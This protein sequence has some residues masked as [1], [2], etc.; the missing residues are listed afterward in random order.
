VAKS[1]SFLYA[2]VIRLES[3]GMVFLG[4]A[5]RERRRNA[6]SNIQKKKVVIVGLTFAV[7]I[8]LFIGL[9]QIENSKK[10]DT[11]G[12]SGKKTGTNVSARESEEDTVKSTGGSDR[13]SD[14]KGSGQDFVLPDPPYIPSVARPNPT[15]AQVNVDCTYCDGTGE[16]TCYKCG[17]D[18]V[19]ADKTCRI[20]KGSGKYNK[21]GFCEGAGYKVEYEDA[22]SDYASSEENTFVGIVNGEKVVGY[23]DDTYQFD[24]KDGEIYYHGNFVVYD[25]G[26][27]AKY[28]L[29]LGICKGKG[30]QTYTSA[31][32]YSSGFSL[33]FSPSLSGESQWS[34][35]YMKDDDWV[36]ALK[37]AE[38]TSSGTFSGTVNAILI[39]GKYAEGAT[40]DVWVCGSFHMSMQEVH[41]VTEKYR[42]LHSDYAAANPHDYY[43]SIS[44]G[45][46]SG[47]YG[48]VLL[49][50]AF[51]SS[52]GGGGSKREQTC[53]ACNGNGKCHVCH[54]QGYRA[55][56][57]SQCNA[58]RCKA[59]RG[60]GLYDHGK[61]VRSC[62][63]CS[64]DGICNI[65]KGTNK[66][67]CSIC[68]GNG[69]CT[70][71][72]GTGKL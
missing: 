40:G 9:W 59:C 38:Y 12:D 26:G 46:G 29:S 34:G 32:K 39:P 33:M 71:C 5:Y 19:Y 62:I 68:S 61:Y 7:V 49:D 1:F 4:K 44:A 8:C 23:L 13:S 30:V 51:G 6:L 10:M 72:G 52:S 20:C 35:M 53:V 43:Q 22:V 41:P 2:W 18:G 70:H 25:S 69:V 28:K 60:T 31:G 45:S 63:V 36:I 17:G 54:G 11:A 67:A 42:A 64:G 24:W 27:T 15:Y 16:N 65:C 58:G 48:G 14:K 55:C 47:S 56:S 50:P 66:V 57:G 37:E 21:C 3:N